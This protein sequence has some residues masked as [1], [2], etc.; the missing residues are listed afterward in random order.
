MTLVGGFLDGPWQA[1]PIGLPARPGTAAG[2]AR[3][4]AA[5][6]HGGGGAGQG[7]PLRHRPRRYQAEING[8]EV[9]DQSSSR[10]G[11]P[12]R[13]GSTT[14]PPTSRRSWHP[15]P[16]PSASGWPAAGS[17]R[18]TAST[19]SRS[20]STASSPPSRW[21]SASSTPTAGGRPWPAARWRATTAG[22]LV[23]SGIY[24]G[25]AFDA[26]RAEAGWSE[27]GF[28]TPMAPRAPEESWAEATPAITP[29]VRRIED[30]RQGSPDHTLRRHGAGFR[31]EPRRPPPDRVSG[32]AGHTSPCGTPRSSRTANCASARCAAAATDTYTLAGTGWGHGVEEW[33][34]RFTFHGFRY[35]QVTTGPASWTGGD[36]RRR[37]PRRH[38]PHRM[39]RVLRPAAEPAAQNVP[40]GHARQLPPPPTDCPQRD[41]RLGWTGDIQVFSPTACYFYDRRL[42]RSWL[43]DLALEQGHATGRPLVVPSVLGMLGSPVAAWG[44]AATSSHGCY[45]SASATRPAPPTVRSMRGWVDALSRGRRTGCGRQIQ[46]GDWLDPPRRRTSPGPAPTRH[47]R[48][49]LPVRSPRPSGARPRRVLGHDDAAT[50]GARRGRAAA[51]LP[52]RHAAGRMVS[53]AQTAYSLA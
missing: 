49:R 52:S 40:L 35:A 44:D 1:E 46:L 3:P 34:P 51:F 41:E 27:P 45:S 30:S 4:A 14:K 11:P 47:R 19:A 53:D 25:K 28:D 26:R 13:T 10:A 18:S 23:S 36:H 29:P 15:A 22:P 38:A 42:P 31:P 37:D 16:T 2:P 7:H 33:E 8:T 12:T 24:A 43:Q 5:R 6:V 39:V 48:Q 32:E 21:S 50:Y 9:D 20:R 17:R